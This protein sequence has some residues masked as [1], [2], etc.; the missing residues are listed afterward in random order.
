MDLAFVDKLAK[1]NN[2]VRY[3][4]VRQDLFDRIVDEKGMKVKDSKETVKTFSKMITKKNR[5][6]KI[7]EDQETEFAGEFDTI[8]SADGIETFSTMG[9]TK[10]A[11][12]EGRI[13]SLKRILYRYVE[14]YGY[15]C[16]HNLPQFIAT[17]NSGNNRSID[18]EPNH[19]KNSDIM[20]ILYSKRLI[21]YRKPKFAIGDR[22]RICKYDLPFRKGFKPHFPQ[23]TFKIVAIATKKPRTYTIKDEQEKSLR[24]KFY[25][26]E[27]I[28]NI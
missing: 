11:F 28:R 18:M 17:T 15:K 13:C 7:W 12:A 14:V 27:M 22:F 21:E 5:P 20:S 25:E 24:G 1:E 3:L 8:C 10:A 2:G 6:K 9:E 4:L 16:F 19:V 23:N 26:K